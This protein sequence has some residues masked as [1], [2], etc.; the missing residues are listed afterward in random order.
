MIAVLKGAVKTLLA[1]PKNALYA[2]FAIGCLVGY[3]FLQA[4][5]TG[6]YDFILTLGACLQTLA[7]ALLVVETAGSATE[8]LSE[9]SLWAF[10]IAHIARISTTIWGEGYTPED[11]TSDIKLYQT[12]E[13][14]GVLLCIFQLLK[15]TTL[16]STQDVGQDKDR[17]T[18]LLGMCG[19]SVV[20][21]YFTKSSGHNDYWADL[22][23]MF[24]V[25]LESFAFLPQ[26]QLMMQNAGRVD[27]T[28]AHF[29]G[30]SMCAASAFGIFWFKHIKENGDL[31]AEYANGMATFTKGISAA[32]IVRVALCAGYLYLFGKAYSS[33]TK[34]DPFAEEM[35]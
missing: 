21:A 5:K 11:N 1:N 28:A 14:I 25:W 8:G 4:Q 17:W 32:C 19:L 10:C 34:N 29:A 20:L 30:L 16:R 15:L 3:T 35:L 33:P 9:K 22:D 7:F 31:N 23:W 6:V 18:V 26:V 24:S 2:L 12:V 13:V 27:E